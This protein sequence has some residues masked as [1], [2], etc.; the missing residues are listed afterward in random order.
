MPAASALVFTSI[1]HFSLAYLV[2]SASAGPVRVLATGVMRT[3]SL[4]IAWAAAGPVA[5]NA[6][7]NAT[8]RNFQNLIMVPPFVETYH[9]VPGALPIGLIPAPGSL[10]PTAAVAAGKL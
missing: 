3:S 9:S 1:F 6:A 2:K 4:S 10:C 8:P 7:T 5:A